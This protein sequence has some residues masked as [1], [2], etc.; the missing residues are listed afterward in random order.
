M[1]VPPELAVEGA[2]LDG[3]GDMGDLNIVYAA[4]IGDGSGDFEQAVVAAGGEAELLDG[5]AHQHGS[6]AAPSGSISL[7]YARPFS[8][9]GITNLIVE[10]KRRLLTVDVFYQQKLD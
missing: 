8:F 7:K 4:E 3:F 6:P 1:S 9:D 10:L 5:G 2:V